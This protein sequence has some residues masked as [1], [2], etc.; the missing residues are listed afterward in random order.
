MNK[1]V[2]IGVLV[3]VILL[4]G[5]VAVVFL[6]R[7][8]QDI[9]SKAATFCDGRW[10]ADP[11]TNC[12][13]NTQSPTQGQGN[14][15][16]TPDFHWD[17]GGYRPEDNGQCVTPTGCS[18]YG[19]GLYLS[20]GSETARPF[21][22]AW[23]QGGSVAVKDAR[24]SQIVKCDYGNVFPNDPNNCHTDGQ[25]AIAPLKPDTTYYWRIVPYFN[26]VDHALHTWNY[27]FTTGTGSQTV[28]CNQ[29]CDA[30][31]VCPSDLTCDTTSGTC[32]NSA[33]LTQTSC[34]CPGA[35]TCDSTAMTPTGTVVT[36]GSETRSLT[37]SGT[38]TGTLEYTWT[39]TGG[40]LSSTTG[41]TVTWT[42]PTSLTSAQTWTI[43]ATVKDSTNQTSTVGGCTK[44]LTFSSLPP[45][46]TGACQMVSASSAVDLSKAKPGDTVT[47][48]GWGS[49]TSDVPADDS[50]DKINFIVSR[51]GKE[52]FNKTVDT[53]L[54]TVKT[55]STLK[56]WQ[57][58]TDY[59]I[60]SAAS[61]TVVIKVHWKNKDKWL[62]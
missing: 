23:I 12:G 29:T 32:R 49:L 42:A 35:P 59:T 22:S 43:S 54:D 20:E 55:T 53:T 30:T 40:T 8:Q 52:D 38:G 27:Y 2:V 4:I 58:K 60:P 6:V 19:I 46:A 50:I 5:L 39:A 24:F 31:H 10:P 62:L 25:P 56:Y 14:V 45:E 16:Q 7:Q 9:R 34:T 15:S 47:F 21:A 1:K 3:G 61:Y 18:Q 13:K 36:A 11:T 26:G 37:A 28:V 44:T 17:Y 51:D 41:S 48:T 33:C 57:G